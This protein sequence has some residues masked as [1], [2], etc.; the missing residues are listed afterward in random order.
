LLIAELL[1][2]VHSD[3]E[4][5]HRPAVGMIDRGQCRARSLR[6]EDAGMARAAKP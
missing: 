5:M 4:A 2:L 6:R 3:S 1:L